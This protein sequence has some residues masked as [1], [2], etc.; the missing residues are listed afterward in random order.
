MRGAPYVPSAI[1]V[2]NQFSRAP[3]I[4]VLREFVLHVHHVL[5]QEFR[6]V[7]FLRGYVEA[8]IEMFRIHFADV[9]VGDV[10]HHGNREREVEFGGVLFRRLRGH[11]A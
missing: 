8:V 7:V 3:L 9:Q 4:I 2:E 10:A 11:S 6:Q 5:F 1:L